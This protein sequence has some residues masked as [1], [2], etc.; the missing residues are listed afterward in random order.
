MTFLSEDEQTEVAAAAIKDLLFLV[1]PSK[2]MAALEIAAEAEE[3]ACA[4]REKCGE[5][6]VMPR[7]EMRYWHEIMTFK[8]KLIHAFTRDIKDA[9]TLLQQ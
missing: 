9:A 5:A 6:R 3:T 8:A 7:F 2:R 4:E 1:P